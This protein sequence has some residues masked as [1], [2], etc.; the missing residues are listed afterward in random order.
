MIA[1]IYSRYANLAA[2]TLPA[3]HPIVGCVSNTKRMV[4]FTK[5]GLSL[6][7]AL[8]QKLTSK[9]FGIAVQ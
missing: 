2:K 8:A 1:G 9:I 4:Q 6:G 7:Q 3:P 5:F